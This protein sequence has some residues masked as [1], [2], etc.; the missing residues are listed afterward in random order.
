LR[1]TFLFL[2]CLGLISAEAIRAQTYTVITSDNFTRADTAAGTVTGPGTYNSP[3]TGA[4]YIDVHGGVWRISGNAL[5][6]PGLNNNG[7]L[8]Y[9]LLRPTTENLL[10][11][12][13]ILTATVPADGAAISSVARAQSSGQTYSAYFYSD[14]SS[15]SGIIAIVA[16][17]AGGGSY[18]TLTSGTTPAAGSAPVTIA[19]T[20]EGTSPTTI[21]ATYSV[22]GSVIGSISATDSTPGLQTTG[23]WGLS[24]TQGIA[25][26]FATYTGF[27]VESLYAVPPALNIGSLSAVVSA[28]NISIGVSSGLSG[29]SGTGYS[30]AIYRG[31]TANFTPGAP[32]ATTS[33]MPYLDSAIVQGTQYF[34]GVVGSDNASHTINAVP[35]GIGTWTPSYLAY[36]SAQAQVQAINLT[37]CGDSITYGAG[38]SNAGTALSPT[39]PYFAA[40]KLGKLFGTRTVY[41]SNQGHSGHTTT[42]FLPATATD[43]PAAKAAMTAL[44]AANPSALQVFSFRLGTNDSASTLTNNAPYTGS[45]P[46]S[47]FQ[48]NVETIT[49]QVLGDFP[50]AKIVWNNASYYTPN[51]HNGAVYEQAGLAYLLLYRT[52]LTVAVAS[53][54]ASAPGRVFVGDTQ[55]FNYFAANYQAELQPDNSGPNGTFYLHPSGTAGSNGL[56]G[57]QTLGEMDATAIAQALFA[58]G[59]TARNYS[60]F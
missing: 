48:A 29:G 18:T 30:Y 53:F 44:I 39:M 35:A 23:Q 47:A 20:L 6:G 26:S 19:I 21:A 49:A 43:Y 34:Y 7:F 17:A 15:G 45:L 8:S 16:V 3:S 27:A 12:E 22:G 2:L 36:V 4:A 60:F 54:S 28:T 10:N 13:S 5:S 24:G 31:T 51:T 50:S 14:P 9:F 37:M 33:S 52:A 11:G 41:V 46:A 1:L 25:G 42:D 38:V 58:A 59:V 40:M 57:T 55:S 32:F 56:I